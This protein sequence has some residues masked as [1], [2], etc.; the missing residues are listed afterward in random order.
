[1]YYRGRPEWQKIGSVERC[2]TNNCCLH[3]PRVQTDISSSFSSKPTENIQ[4]NNDQTNI[5]KTGVCW[6][7]NKQTTTTTTSSEFQIFQTM[8]SYQQ[9]SKQYANK[10]VRIF[11]YLCGAFYSILECI[12]TNIVYFIAYLYSFIYEWLI[13]AGNS[14]IISG[15]STASIQNQKQMQ[16]TIGETTAE[17]VK[18][19]LQQQ[20]HHDHEQQQQSSSTNAN[21]IFQKWSL[22]EQPVV[23]PVEFYSRKH[24]CTRNFN[25]PIL[26]NSMISSAPPLPPS[27]PSTFSVSLSLP[28]TV[29]SSMSTKDG[30]KVPPKGG[31]AVLPLDIMAEAHARV[32]QREQR[33]SEQNAESQEN[34]EM[35]TDWTVTSKRFAPFKWKTLTSN[36][37]EKS[38][39]EDQ[40]NEDDE[41]LKS[42]RRNIVSRISRPSDQDAQFIFHVSTYQNIPSNHLP[43]GNFLMGRSVFS[44][45]REAEE[46]RDRVNRRMTETPSE[47]LFESRLNTPLDDFSMTSHVNTPLETTLDS[48]TDFYSGYP[49]S[50][51]RSQSRIQTVFSPPLAKQIHSPRR[52][53]NG[54]NMLRQRSKTVEPRLAEGTVK[55]LTR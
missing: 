33:L 16:K 41:I 39:V 13:S 14:T 37:K 34:N 22:V 49:T 20:Y 29:I 5:M 9:I 42:A 25:G 17:E 35:N 38:M 18:A 30:E 50:R 19:E 24:I 6:R 21:I 8:N 53:E 44:P 45:V 40:T 28:K 47:S 43:N 54:I 26:E 23:E 12:S 2:T 4:K 31:V 52:D 3:N 11:R 10:T 55:A 32:K 46:M 27:L 15:T 1:M 48:Y 36:V 7:G 51:S